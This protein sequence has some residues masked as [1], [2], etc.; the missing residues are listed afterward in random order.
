[1]T[2]KEFQEKALNQFTKEI[3]DIFFLYIENDKALFQDYLRVIGR[4]SDL[5]NTNQTLGEA[6]KI[7]FN[8]ENGNKNTEPESYLIKSYTEHKR[9]K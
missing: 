9:K 3:T 2:I 5:D 4:E 8:L 7:W 6:I 1:M